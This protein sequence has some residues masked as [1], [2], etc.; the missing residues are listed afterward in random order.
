MMLNTKWGFVRQ[1]FSKFWSDESGQTTT[2]Y[3]LILAV[4]FAIA[5]KFKSSIVS[6][7]S[8]QVDKM[9]SQM[10]QLMDADQ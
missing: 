7:I 6:K 3:M 10:D 9:G 5:M 2:E 4:V 8:G 1:K